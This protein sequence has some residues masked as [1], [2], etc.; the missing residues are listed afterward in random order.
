MLRFWVCKKTCVRVYVIAASLGLLA[1]ATPMTATSNTPQE[2]P[3]LQFSDLGYAGAFRLPST[4]QGD[5]FEFAGRAMAYNPARNSLFISSR[6]GN[7][8]E[9]SIPTPAITSNVN[10]MPFAS[11]LQG[12]RDPTEGHFREIAADG[13]ALSGLYVHG[14][15]LYGTG[16]I[17][18]DAMNSQVVSHFSHSTELSQPSFLGMSQVWETGKAGYVSGYMASIPSEWQEVLGGSAITGQC[19]IPIVTRTSYG[20]AAFAWN[21]LDVGRQNQV[22]ATPLLYYSSA[23]QTLGPWDG[24]NPTYGGTVAMGG[25]ALIAG[26]RTALFIGRNGA[27]DF[28]YGNGTGIQALAG[29][30]GPDGEPYCY[31]PTSSDK[32]QH[33]Y[34]YRYQIWAYDLNEFA[35]VKAGAK[36]PWEVRPYAVW[37]F[38]LPVP[39]PSVLI[40]GVSYDAQR[41]VIYLLQMRADQDGYAYRPLVHVL[42]MNAPGA[43][44]LPSPNIAKVAVTL[45]SNIPSPQPLGTS[46]AWTAQATGGNA[47]YQYKW[48]TYSNGSWSAATDWTTTASFTWKPT[49]ASNDARV[50]VWVRGAGSTADAGEASAAESF[51]INDPAGSPV[52]AV[53]LASNL[54][55]PQAAGTT[56]RWLAVPVGGSDH[57]YKWFVNDGG[58]WSAV[59]GWVTSN[60]FDWTPAKANPGYRVGVWVKRASNPADTLEASAE[61]PF[62]VTG[63]L[64]APAPTATVTL[65]T[66]LASP[67]P[68]GTPITVTAA[69][70]SGAYEFKWFLFNGSWLPLSGWVSSNTYQWTPAAANGGYILGVWIRAAGSSADTPLASAEKPFAITQGVAVPAKVTSV[71][72]TSNIKPTHVGVPITWTATPVGGVAPYRYQWWVLQDGKNWVAVGGWTTANSYVWIPTNKNPNTRV[73]VWV[74]SAGSSSDQAEATAE[75]RVTFK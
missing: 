35:A 69:A 18:Y 5:T 55:S 75:I 31:D 9:V 63:S 15:R 58:A 24:S 38:D 16:S 6:A 60:T 32:G 45:A 8:A 28:C 65:A 73:A 17:F 29:T 68:V 43:A 4:W 41:Q 51:E 33:A 48:R 25:A 1:F 52:T 14:D 66:N 13:A 53:T 7:V 59:T 56:V 57:R 71:S 11:Y 10:E 42:K 54:T 44:P 30:K 40:G 39:E 49:T 26:T 62:A 20:P 50:G 67:Q 34:P 27:G 2:Q 36:Q 21:P 12:F 22:S 72:L 47:P 61:S 46:I 70:G 37:P 64:E 19:C 3:L 74:K 23:H